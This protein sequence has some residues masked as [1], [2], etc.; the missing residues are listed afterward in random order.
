MTIYIT[1]A[2]I[3]NKCIKIFIM[4]KYSM[5]GGGAPFKVSITGIDGAGKDTVTRLALEMVSND[6]NQHTVKIGRP[7]YEWWEWSFYSNL[8]TYD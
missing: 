8:P 4:L 5:E 2:K 6:G 7:A 3:K 1:L